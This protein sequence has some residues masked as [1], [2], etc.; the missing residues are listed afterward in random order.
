[1][2]IKG[3]ISKAIGPYNRKQYRISIYVLHAW[4]SIECS[5]AFPFPQATSTKHNKAYIHG[6]NLLCSQ[7]LGTH[8][9][10]ISWEAV[11]RSAYV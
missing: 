7:L 1:M 5:S 3:S 4:R 2:Y 11:S 6:S 9:V 10:A 8:L